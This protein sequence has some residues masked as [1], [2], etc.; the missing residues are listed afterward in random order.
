MASVEELVSRIVH[1][2]DEQ[3]AKEVYMMA[4]DSGM[5]L[6]SSQNLYE[7]RAR[8]EWSGF[9]VPAFNIRTLVFDAARAVFRQAVKNEAGAFIFELARSES[10]YTFQSMSEYVP[11][12]LAAGLKEGYKGGVF[13]Q[14]DHYQVKEK[15]FF[16]PSAKEDEIS[17]LKFLLKEAIGSGV[18]NIDIDAS[19]LVRAH[20]KDLKFQQKHNCEATALLT[21]FARSLEPGG[22]TVSLGGEVG[23]IG[24]EN[25]TIEDVRTF[26]EGY[27]EELSKYGEMKG[28]IKLAVQTG[29]SHGGIMGPGGEMIEPDIDFA[30]LKELSSEARKHGMAGVVQHGAST[31]PEECFDKFPEAETLEIHL[32]TAFQNI[33]L[34]SEYFPE[35][36]KERMQ[37]WICEHCEKKENQTEEQFLYENRKKALG[38]F[39]KEI[40]E[41]SEEKRGRISQELEEK[42]GFLFL[43]LGIFGTKETVNKIY[44]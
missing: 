30:L 10:E 15:K 35:D 17:S 44:K 16:D 6:A 4:S 40:M 42:F 37:V 25:S 14:G 24:R 38:P 26:A 11:M 33:V 9:T 19:T 2:K 32:A 31:L 1:K 43:K 27:K 41:I 39:K 5:K 12:I 28:L 22:I 29:A 8:G 3:A 20:E 13:F 23:E 21:S 36:L 34:D 7:A 18:Y